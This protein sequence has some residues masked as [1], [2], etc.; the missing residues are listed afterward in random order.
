MGW[1]EWYGIRK[2][3]MEWGLSSGRETLEGRDIVD[4]V[5]T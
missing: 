4:C 2:V 5:T 3:D 1:F